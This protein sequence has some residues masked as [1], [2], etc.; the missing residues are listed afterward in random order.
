MSMHEWI[1]EAA[2]AN[3]NAREWAFGVIAGTIDTKMTPEEIRHLKTMVETLEIGAEMQAGVILRKENCSCAKCLAEKEK[4][5]L[6][7]N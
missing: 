1:K 2:Q 6:R 5:R 7:V 3:D 4:R